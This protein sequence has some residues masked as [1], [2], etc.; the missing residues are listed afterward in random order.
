MTSAPVIDPLTWDLNPIY[1]G[2]TDP[3]IKSDQDTARTRAEDFAS[4]YRGRIA[5]LK[6]DAFRAMMNALESIRFLVNRPVW[7]VGLRFAAQTDDQAVKNLL[8]LVRARAV[9]VGNVLTFAQLEL[10]NLPEEA[11][12]RLLEGSA[13]LEDYTHAIASGRRFGPHTLSEAEERLISTKSLTGRAAWTQLY[14]ELSSAIRIV[15]DHDGETRSLTVDEARALRSRPEREVRR[16]AQ[17]KLFAA[18]AEREQV[19]TYIF[20]VLYQ[21][22]KFETHLRRYDNP[23]APTILRDELPA[24]SVSALMDTT[25]AN[26]DL[27]QAYY[28]LK[29]RLLGIEEFS[30]FDTLAPYSTTPQQ[31]SFDEG[32]DLVLEAV[33]GFS[34]ELAALCRAFFTER[35]IDVMPRPGKR[36]GAFCSSY[37]PNDSA[38]I[39]LNW[40]GRLD[41]VFTLAHELGHGIHAELSRGQNM[42]NFGHSLPLAETASVFLEMVLLDHLMQRADAGTRRNLIATLIE[43]AIGT[44]FRQVQITRWE[45]LA[46][47]ERAQG[48]VSSARY[49]ELWMGTYHTI[50][51]D[52]VKPTALDRWGWIGIP[53]VVNSRFYCYSYAFGNLLV[54]ALYQRYRQ[55]GAAFVPK[56]LGFLS[57]GQSASPEVLV[58]R[59]GVNINDPEFWQSGFDFLKRQFETFRSLV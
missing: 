31:Y 43:D 2:L 29:A 30:S 33:G 37:S 5:T 28:L 52:A 7:Y 20:N 14:T 18:F 22:W 25:F 1:A 57:S 26:T 38:F 32:R 45:Q 49:G 42:T 13:S 35:R 24:A 44:T 36:G 51:G 15:F 9:E 55:E 41:D 11:E 39:L 56:Y 12:R 48:V 53:H 6:P 27:V 10:A 50:Y 3:R 58:S 54:Y 47:A 46:H 40:N 4:M 19:L 59:L 8:D 16:Q 17:E 34:P 21:D 23:I